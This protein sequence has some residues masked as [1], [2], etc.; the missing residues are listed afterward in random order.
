MKLSLEVEVIDQPPQT[1]RKVRIDEIAAIET[2]RLKR[3]QKQTEMRLWK[4]ES[5]QTRLTVI[6]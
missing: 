6:E 4:A 5:P 2:Q 1:Q 3:M